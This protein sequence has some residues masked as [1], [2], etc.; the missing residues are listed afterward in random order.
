MQILESE[1][2][3]T[4]INDLQQQN[5]RWQSVMIRAINIASS[6]PAGHILPRRREGSTSTLTF[7]VCISQFLFSSSDSTIRRL[8]RANFWIWERGKRKEERGKGEI[9]LSSAVQASIA[10][11][12]DHTS[13]KTAC[14][15]TF[16]TRNLSG[17]MNI[18]LGSVSAKEG[19]K[20]R[21]C[22]LV[23]RNWGGLLLDV[24]CCHQPV[25]CRDQIKECS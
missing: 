9:S 15:T 1:N 10:F 8:F 25:S 18:S 19:G 21:S 4:G 5:H 2:I 20:Y 7:P 23:W 24:F 16:A 11:G 14:H 6:I 22:E 17:S 13:H 3:N 12:C